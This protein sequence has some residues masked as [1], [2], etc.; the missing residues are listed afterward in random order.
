MTTFRQKL[1][2]IVLSLF[3]LVF[4]VLSFD[5]LDSFQSKNSQNYKT[6]G[7]WDLSPVLLQMVAGEFK[8]LMADYLT[9]DVGAQLGTEVIR[10]AEGKNLRVFKKTDCGLAL[11]KFQASQTLDPSFAHNMIL[12]QG[13]LPWDCQM[14]DE[15]IAI[16]EVYD[17]NRPWDWQPARF[18]AF[19]N[20]YFLNNRAEAGR[21]FL[22]AAKKDNALPYFSLIGARL[23]MEGGQN[24][25]ALWFVQSMLQDMP[26]DDPG[27]KDLSERYQA[28]Q[29][30]Q[31]LNRAKDLY[32]KQL[33]KPL[34]AISDLVSSGILSQMPENPYHIEYCLD[35]VG[36]IHF[37]NV[38]CK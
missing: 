28:L 12:A 19:N 25:T 3:F 22:E 37:D 14:V 8:G 9:V 7:V 18:L 4:Y 27:Y 2:N 38:N 35:S 16:L 15:T 13:W 1:V 5:S 6:V 29:G 34:Q 24:E 31:V 21:I 23:S 33:G 36:L 17:V 10:D 26:K 11:K 32:Q 20:Y 30:V